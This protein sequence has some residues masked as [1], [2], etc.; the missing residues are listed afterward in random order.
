MEQN[1]RE[2]TI[3]GLTENKSYTIT[4]APLSSGGTTGT[5][6]SKTQSTLS[7]SAPKAPQNLHVSNIT[8][9]SA[10]LNWSRASGSWVQSYDVT[11]VATNVKTNVN[12]WTFSRVIT[13][14]TPDTEYSYIVT[15]KNSIDT[16]GSYKITFRTDK[17]NSFDLAVKPTA[18]IASK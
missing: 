6:V 14:L 2:H 9:T 5:S 10:T 17:D 11:N 18:T 7:K 13:G 8:P 15:A 1:V 3:T 12:W 16:K 4:L